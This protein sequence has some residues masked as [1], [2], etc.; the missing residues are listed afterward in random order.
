MGS[1]RNIIDWTLKFEMDRNGFKQISQEFANLKT[2]IDD[3]SSS[4]SKIGQNVSNDLIGLQGTAKQAVGLTKQE[5][6]ALKDEIGAIETALSKSFNKNLGTLNVST[7]NKEITNSKINLQDFYRKLNSPEIGQK[8]PQAFRRLTAEILGTNLQLR[9][10]SEFMNNLMVSFSNTVKWGITSSIFNNITNSIQGAW[11][12]AKKLDTS[13]NDIRIVTGKSGDE[14]ER[15][16]REA[17]RAAASLGKSTTDYTQASLIYYQQG[18]QE[19]DVKARTAT[20]LKAASVTGQ[21]TAA[22]SEQLTAVWNGYKV[23]A[24]EAELYVDKLAAVAAETAADLEELSVGMSK[25]ASAASLMGVDIDQLS[26]QMATIISVTRQA[27]ESVGTAL[28]TIY[29]RMGDIEAGIDTE[30]TLGEYTSKMAEMGINV[31]DMNG[32]LK[33]MGSVIEEIGQKWTSLTREE[34]IALSQTI[35]G[36]R[37]YNNLLALFDNWDS[38]TKTLNTSIGA[39]GTLQEQQDIYM[40]STAAHLEKLGAA[41]EKVFDAFFNNKGMNNLI[42]L[43]TTLTN[44]LGNFIDGIGGGLNF[45]TGATGILIKQYKG[46]LAS[47]ILN[48]LGYF[49]D[50]KENHSQIVEQN[51]ILDSIKAIGGVNLDKISDQATK[52]IINMKKQIINLGD[53]VSKEEQNEVN[54]LIKLR[55]R[56]EEQ[57]E[58]LE[59]R[60]QET[61]EY[62][63]LLAKMQSMDPL[64]KTPI[65]TQILA[66]GKQINY[67]SQETEKQI[68]DR[69][70]SKTDLFATTSFSQMQSDIESLE[71]K[72]QELKEL[73]NSSEGQEKRSQIQKSIENLE[74]K[75]TE[76]TAS[77]ESALLE[78]N[79]AGLLEAF[80]DSDDVYKEVINIM[81]RIH[82]R[83][84]DTVSSTIHQLIDAKGNRETDNAKAAIEKSTSYYRTLYQNF[85]SIIGKM[86][87]KAKEANQFLQHESEKTQN[88][89]IQGMQEVKDE[90]DRILNEVER[91]Q[92]TS[93]IIGIVGAIGQLS[94]ALGS[95]I[96]TFKTIN[97]E[98]LTLGE[99]IL[100]VT[101]TLAYVIPVFL[102]GWKSI[103]EEVI[104]LGVNLGFVEKEAEGAFG[105]TIKKSLAAKIS[106]GGVKI[107]LGK[108][109][110]LIIAM[111]AAI[112]G[113][114]RMWTAHNRAANE[115]ESAAKDLSKAFSETKTAAEELKKTISDYGTAKD[116]L[117]ELGKSTKEY[118]EALEQ[119]NEQAR[120]LIENH[121]L[122]EGIDYKYKG[123][124]I[125][126]NPDKL[127]ELER[128]GE[129]KAREAEN[130]ALFAQAQSY[131]AQMQ[132]DIIDLKRTTPKDFTAD[133]PLI[134]GKNQW[135]G[136][137]EYRQRALQAGLI[138]TSF[139]EESAF[140]TENE[141]S[142]IVDT[143]ARLREVYKDNYDVI[144]SN[145]NS[146][147]KALLGLDKV[148]NVVENNINAIIKSKNAFDKVAEQQ[149]SFALA[150]KKI[151][152]NILLNIIREK[153]GAKIDKMATGEDGKVDAAKAAQIELAMAKS[154][155]ARE[156]RWAVEAGING[157][158]RTSMQGTVTGMY[159]WELNDK[160]KYGEFAYNIKNDEDLARTYAKEILG[161]TDKE[162]EDLVYKRDK[163]NKG[164]FVDLEGN[165]VMNYM[166]DN[167]MRTRLAMKALEKQAAANAGEKFDNSDLLSDMEAFV[168]KGEEAGRKMGT[169][170]STVFLDTIANQNKEIDFSSIFTELSPSEV[171]KLGKMT[172][173]ELMSFFGFTSDDLKLMGFEAAKDFQ[174]AVQKG[175]TGYKWNKE[176]SIKA[177]LNSLLTEEDKDYADEIETYAKQIMSQTHKEND[178]ADS[179]EEDAQMATKVA[180]AINRMNRGL[181]D[182]HDNIDDWITKLKTSN[183]MSEDYA[184][185]IEGISN[186]LGQLLGVNGK[187][188]NTDFVTSH[189]EQIKQA[190]DGDI[191]SIES[192]RNSL[193]DNMIDSF[194]SFKGLDTTQIENAKT[195]IDSLQSLIEDNNFQIGL[196]FD[197]DGELDAAEE[198]VV[199]TMN[200]IIKEAGLGVD[201]AN[202]LFSLMGFEATYEP[203]EIENATGAEIPRTI[204]KTRVDS[205]FPNL[206]ISQWTEQDGT[207]P[208]G[209]GMTVGN[210]NIKT[211]DGKESQNTTP[212]VKSARRIS[213]NSKFLNK[214]TEKGGKSKKSKMDPI[215][216]DINRFHDIDIVLGEIQNDLEKVARAQEKAFGKDLLEEYNKEILLLDKNI[217][218]TDKKIQIAKDWMNDLRK[219]NKAKGIEKGLEEYGFIFDEDGYI[220]NYE[221]YFRRREDEINALI[222]QHEA[223]SEG[224]AKEAFREKIEKEKDDLENVK[225]LFEKYE[226]L[227]YETIP[228]QI[229][230]KEEDINKQIEQQINKFNLEIEIRLDLKEAEEDWNEFRKNVLE[231]IKED[232]VLRNAQLNL[233]NFGLYY[234][235]NENGIIQAGTRQVNNI[236][237]ELKAMD[238]T[239]QSQVY[240]DNRAKALEEL[241]TYY[242][243]LKN[244]LTDL[245]ALV[246]EIQQ[247]YLDMMGQAQEAFD[248]QINSYEQVSE[249]LN[250]DMK[251][252]QLIRGEDSYKELD[253]Y[254][255]KLE[256]N[257]RKQLDF[258]KQEVDFWKNQMDSLDPLQDKEAWEN[259]KKNWM[260][261]T[262]AWYSKIETSIE[263]L[264]DKYLN[265]IN[266]IFDELN[267]KVTDGKGLEYISEE[268]DLLSKNSDEFLDEI[269]AL[270]G[271]EDIARK[272]QD[273]IDNTDNL[274]I[275]KKLKEIMEQELKALREKDKLTEYDIERAEKKYDLTLKQ[276]ALEEAQ[277][278]KSQ[279]RL[280]RDSQGNYTYQY[281]ADAD[282]VK[283]AEEELAKARNEL[284]N[285]DLEQYKD[286]LEQLYDVYAEYQDKM[287][288]AA[289]INDPE[290]RAA[291]ELLLQQQYGEL[292][293]GLVAQN[294]DIRNNLY[295][296]AFAE[297]AAL[298]NQELTDFTNL[299][300][301]EKDL[302]MNNLIPEWDSGIQHMAD[303]FAGEGGFIPVCEESMKQLE[304]ATG[305]YEKEL[306]ALEDAAGV[307]F[308]QI[309]KGIDKNI[310]E[311]QG[312]IEKNDE[313]INKYEE[314]LDAIDSVMDELDNL[315]DRY[316][317]AQEAA[318]AATEAAYDYWRAA[319]NEA[320]DNAKNDKYRPEKEDY[321]FDKEEESVE[322]DNTENKG[323]GV[324]TIGETVT[325][326][327]GSGRWYEDSFG[328]GKSGTSSSNRKVTITRIASNPNATHPYHIDQ[329]G[330]VTENQLKEYEASDITNT[331]STSSNSS[332]NKTTT[333]KKNTTTTTPQQT[334][335]NTNINIPK[336]VLNN[337]PDHLKNQPIYLCQLEDRIGSS[338]NTMLA[339]LDSGNGTLEQNVHIDANFPNVQS[340][341]EIEDAIN[342][343][344]N[345]ASQ[346]A[347]YA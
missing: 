233:E 194:G 144:F 9:Q 60:T 274:T 178:F 248:E 10:T 252:I 110:L 299:T 347:Y 92:L 175:L 113:I 220:T 20:T 115:A 82:E 19:E 160:K 53:I 71:K 66:N 295:E 333:T 318:E 27:P 81:E 148:P 285:F 90:Y 96:N 316:R 158:S 218:A 310:R 209:A 231:D 224:D 146:L 260:D 133:K 164:A 139:N 65:D 186:S 311:T 67:Y 276:I 89:I 324:F 290:E 191:A 168:D 117:Q 341:K 86:K 14:M 201:E 268:W 17:N 238:E 114:Y 166:D 216:E 59:A 338:S 134:Y 339:S 154:Q 242:D 258:Q 29:A 212:V 266:K 104:G 49:Q 138:K 184:V 98:S 314:E 149:N 239:G 79:E 1:Q 256:K 272:Y 84:I 203:T 319:N 165:T 322:P 282:E 296:S 135:T 54:Y 40:E 225:E 312:L 244:D 4:D 61:K 342:N 141:V 99:K 249:I 292:I 6:K 31:L 106:I 58:S 118:K 85:D 41:W 68:L 253:K 286:K 303:I 21:S 308:N 199:E 105:T 198:K 15:F 77:L 232:D 227:K 152:D 325:F 336:S 122:L 345:V 306:D 5:L 237:A 109:L 62:I 300:Q 91:R 107:A 245:D 270:Y 193:A 170:F 127:A 147:K 161:K 44:L 75:I 97:N 94:S 93:T 298:R 150:T 204:T 221:A 101:T 32:K 261:A 70:T 187:Y 181:Q 116:K 289:Q 275:Q 30:T 251:I 18:L 226:E 219:G 48:I 185:A 151:V 88:E 287:K 254:Y 23:S 36:T 50:M 121:K 108:L 129:S 217:A 323:D 229:N 33:D 120:A 264:Q 162:L 45:L 182:L 327:G 7:F 145:N 326:I 223:M 169:D 250:H 335:K 72:L 69:I 125:K 291:R 271:I 3:L 202:A 257:N 123:G 43:G 343:L 112:Y 83:S 176:A 280:R 132:E 183:K 95:V 126:I 74:R 35:A 337:I 215:K 167:E 302:L 214:P 304:D 46:P 307:N 313:L 293:N 8:G 269:N 11:S 25:V 156:A 128:A 301:A 305:E 24:Q 230:Q 130:T 172:Q 180:L 246:E 119:A 279:L 80:A 131:K 153:Y 281:V 320:A 265:T 174:D 288:E 171:S 22:V 142:S 317:E 278:N 332:S 283:K 195:E 200:N 188:I 78:L 26:A 2:I 315:I 208:V 247:S 321:S 262:D 39:V 277:Q 207:E 197:A 255:E 136:Q 76:E 346:R 328:G 263:D 267:N 42:D 240:G 192:L 28:K 222:N 143:F 16:A 140:Y 344:T 330:W 38:Y 137:H 309:A 331:Q 159:N 12:Y 294:E 163:L 179:L 13:L 155:E 273:A 259:A 55:A 206:E 63:D 157:N 47:E 124:L 334:T 284:Y 100:Q 210:L 34:Q 64:D 211:K 190:A 196:D 329:L 37:Q 52:D 56:F 51:K 205:W 241:K 297:L 236:L 243:Q 87:V 111:A 235:D 102:N 73:D 173:Q 57:Q 340:S 213:G 177:S 103:K 189:L 234:K 228:E